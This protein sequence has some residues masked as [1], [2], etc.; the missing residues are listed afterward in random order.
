MPRTIRTKINTMKMKKK[1]KR[2]LKISDI[3]NVKKRE[4]K[5]L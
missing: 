4:K 2:I 5:Y 1:K 3:L